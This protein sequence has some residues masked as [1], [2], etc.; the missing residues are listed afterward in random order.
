[1]GRKSISGGVRPKGRN[2]I[3]FDFEFDGVRYR[4]TLTR[5]PTEANLRRARAQLTDIKDRIEHGV[6]AFAEEFPDFRFGKFL[7]KF[8]RHRTCDQV[9]DEYLEHARSR[10]VKNDMAF[11]TYDGYRRILT[12]VWRPRIGKRLFEEIRYTELV[13]IADQHACKKKTYNNVVSALRCAFSYGY[14]DYPE[15]HNPATGVRCLRI[16]KKDRRPI[17]P[18]SIYEAEALI[19]AIHM[20][21]GEAQGNYEEFRFFT[22]MRPSEQ[23]EL[24]VSDCDLAQGKVNIT[25]A[26]VMA[27]D[28][29]RTKTSVDRLIELC[30]RALAVLKRQLA[31]RERLERE[32]RI[33]HQAVFF[34]EDGY[35]WH[36]LQTQWRRWNHTLQH[37]VKGRYREPYNA[38][39]S[40]VS[41]N[42]MI[43]K[44]PLKIAKQHGHSVETMLD[45]YAAWIDG[46]TDADVQAIERAM[47]AGPCP[48]VRLEKSPKGSAN[49]APKAGFEFGTGFGTSMAPGTGRG[50]LSARKRRENRW[51]RVR[52][53]NPRW[54]FDPYALSRGAPSTTRPTLRCQRKS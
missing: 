18:F 37:T 9:F 5:V 21:W 11:A 28:K 10:M 1:M 34:H 33:T 7:P 31:L 54:A 25:K 49:Q 8:S 42:L 46:T 45:V 17:D 6:F 51:R 26:R 50:T 32:G 39:H 30:P 23:I 14:A 16:T 15:K 38:R 24:L 29:D 2:R 12:N 41:W 19:A 3:Q 44:N 40:S 13:K 36:D 43:G 52:D 27:R 20:E 35:A 22:G 47:A 4:P 48:V 53:S